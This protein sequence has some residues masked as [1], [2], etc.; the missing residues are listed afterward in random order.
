MAERFFQCEGRCRLHAPW[1]PVQSLHWIATVMEALLAKPLSSTCCSRPSRSRRPSAW[2]VRLQITLGPVALQIQTTTRHRVSVC[3]LHHEAIH[4][5][6]LHPRPVNFLTKLAMS[7]TAITVADK[8]ILQD[9]HLGPS[10]LKLELSA[11]ISAEVTGLTR[12]H[13]PDLRVG[14]SSNLAGPSVLFYGNHVRLTRKSGKCASCSCPVEEPAE[15]TLRK[16]CPS[17][18]ETK[19]MNQS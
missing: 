8:I 12:T 2:P 13:P 1:D 16:P 17:D 9:L 5:R 15:S 7:E 11:F 3:A 14:W 10:N 6:G 4:T 19:Q 18:K